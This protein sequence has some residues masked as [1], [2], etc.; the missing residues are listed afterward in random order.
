MQFYRKGQ[1]FCDFMNME[2]FNQEQRTALDCPLETHCVVS[3]GPGSGK[4]QFL[5]ARAARVFNDLPE[6]RSHCV[7][8]TNESSNEMRRR[9]ASCIPKCGARL[10]CSTIHKFCLDGLNALSSDGIRVKIVRNDTVLIDVLHE[11]IVHIKAIVYSELDA[12]VNHVVAQKPADEVEDLIDSDEDSTADDFQIRT[13]GPIQPTES[14]LIYLKRVLF[15]FRLINKQLLPLG[16]LLH[17]KALQGVYGAFFRKLDE[18]HVVDF[19]LIVSL[20]ACKLEKRKKLE[21]VVLSHIFI[22]EFQ[23]LDQEQ[24]SLVLLLVQFGV[25]VT[26]VGDPNQ[27]IYSWRCPELKWGDAQGLVTKKA[28]VSTESNFQ[29]IWNRLGEKNVQLFHLRNNHRST[30]VIVHACN[31]LMDDSKASV[32]QIQTVGAFVGAFVAR[33]P[34]EELQLVI[35]MIKEWKLQKVSK[36]CAVLFRY[37]VDKERLVKLLRAADLEFRTHFKAASCLSP[38]IVRRSKSLL[39]VLWLMRAVGFPEDSISVLHA[40]TLGCG[41]SVVERLQKQF[42]QNGFPTDLLEKAATTDPIQSLGASLTIP[43]SNVLEVLRNF[44]T[45]PTLH[46]QCKSAIATFVKRMDELG[47]CQTVDEMVTKI[48]LIF[49][50]QKTKD[51]SEFLLLI[52]ASG[53]A[54]NALNRIQQH[55]RDK[56][57]KRNSTEGIFVGT[58][59]SGKGREW[60]KVILPHVNEGVIPNDR[61]CNVSEERRVLYVGMTR[62]KTKLIL[63]CTNGNGV[64]PSRF[65]FDTKMSMTSDSVHFATTR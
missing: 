13:P 22:D 25:M 8:F 49:K 1:F 31:R 32:A 61:G 30:S 36:D 5:I 50:V 63:T 60:D 17:S 55:E 15:L 19:H 3:A 54:R 7:S 57:A 39:T 45:D 59:H 10:Q 46:Y 64:H 2:L 56:E 14:D 33:S 52:P 43:S 51:L 48:C 40:C 18:M 38:Q 28:R 4:T 21:P 23:D 24:L 62:A 35:R 37:N 27:S 12:I 58:I 44:L 47:R 20:F 26:A 41:K 34:N 42:A 9:I 6:S 65:L 53:T 16:L 29:A 11:I